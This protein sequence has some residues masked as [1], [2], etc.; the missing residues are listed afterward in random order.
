MNQKLILRLFR[1]SQLYLLLLPAVAMFAVPADVFK[2]YVLF[3]FI[4]SIFVFAP[5]ASVIVELIEPP[6]SFSSLFS[7]YLLPI[8]ILI[9]STLMLGKD[10]TYF[11][12]NAYLV[13]SVALLVCLVIL[14]L[15]AGPIMKL[16]KHFSPTS[17]SEVVAPITEDEKPK[18]GFSIFFFL[19]LLMAIFPFASYLK[20]MP[21]LE[22]LLLVPVV[23]VTS[24]KYIHA[25]LWKTRQSDGVDLILIS[26]FALV[27][28]IIYRGATLT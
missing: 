10:I 15:F 27:V 19:I 12:R 5:Y 18:I 21:V 9:I 17:H 1:I 13:E 20:S 24:F 8:L 2:Y 7:K 4:G 23:L 22:I 14:G 11:A 25:I 16:I 26:V 28:A 3:L 6:T